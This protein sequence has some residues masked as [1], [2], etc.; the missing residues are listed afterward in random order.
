[1]GECVGVFFIYDNE[2]KK[3]EEFKD[4]YIESGSTIYEVIRVI[5]GVPLFLKNHLERLHNSANIKKVVLKYSDSEINSKLTQLIK[6]NAVNNGNIK[7]IFNFS[8]SQFFCTYFIKHSYP[9]QEM[10]QNGVSV[11]LFHG[12]RT[13]PN[14]KVIDSSFRSR[15]EE[16]IKFNNAYEAILVN[17][18]GYITEGSK[19]NIFMIKDDLVITAPGEDV[20]IGVTRDM[21][22]K[23]CSNLKIKCIESRV[24]YSE[25]NDIDALFI[26]GTSP[27]VLPINKI[28]L[29]EYSSPKN[30]LVCKIITEYNN[31]INNYVK[32]IKVQ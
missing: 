9:S 18:Q 31:I 23:A 7:L 17:N 12:E 6:I 32:N 13:N 11:I 3:N 25:L 30:D 26:S 4:N 10:Y 27:K 8:S 22:M 29:K 28:D 24:H 16:K 14:A 2:I 5:D 21:I 15:V 19:S 20:L 1:M